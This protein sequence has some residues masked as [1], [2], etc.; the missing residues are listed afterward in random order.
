LWHG[1]CTE[2]QL[3]ER[4]SDPA[5]FGVRA[6][7][8]GCREGSLLSD[9][10]GAVACYRPGADALAAAP[11]RVAFLVGDESMR[12]SIGRTAVATARL[13][14]HEVTVFPSHH[15]RFLGGEFLSASRSEAFARTLCRHRRGDRGGVAS[16]TWELPNAADRPAVTAVPVATRSG[17]PRRAG[18][19]PASRYG[20]PRAARAATRVRRRSAM[21]SRPPTA[22]YWL[23]TARRS[24]SREQ[25]S[26]SIARCWPA[27]GTRAAPGSTASTRCDARL[28]VEQLPGR[29][30]PASPRLRQPYRGV[31][32]AAERVGTVAITWVP[33]EANGCARALVAE[34][35]GTGP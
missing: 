23:F 9:R 24:A 11:T 3:A 10:S 21:C 34:A 32:D 25:T 19:A 1:E 18:G 15:G 12:A 4:A 8:D 28:V 2:E 31:R 14:G 26:P 27:S 33:A 35:L 22:P 20:R 13:L 30:E 29:R 7:D 5:R 17:A 6:E 16:S